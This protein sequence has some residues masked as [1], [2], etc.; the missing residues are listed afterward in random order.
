M[1]KVS[2]KVK[3]KMQWDF[4]NFVETVKL[5]H[6]LILMQEILKSTPNFL[7][8]AFSMNG[9]ETPKW[10]PSYW[11]LLPL[12]AQGGRT[13]IFQEP[14]GALSQEDFWK[15]WGLLELRVLGDPPHTPH[16]TGSQG[17]SAGSG[18]HP[19]LPTRT[20][21]TAS[22][23]QVQSFKVKMAAAARKGG[24]GKT[25]SPAMTAH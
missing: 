15:G 9:L 10:N 22:W 5:K 1:D 6:K 20:S 21:K 17:S 23:P 8:I 16:F 18:D 2:L 25:V 14:A 12:A 13:D 19:R 4:E 24:W 7:R 3:C 11:P